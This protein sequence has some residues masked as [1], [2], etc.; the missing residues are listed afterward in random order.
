MALP[1]ILV[2]KEIRGGKTMFN[3]VLP[4][5]TDPGSEV[6]EALVA[7]AGKHSLVKEGGGCYQVAALTVDA[8]TVHFLGGLYVAPATLQ[9]VLAD[10]RTR[11]F[12]IESKA[13]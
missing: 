10:L 13:E 4:G 7:I 5:G 1:K 12:E 3:L 11:G 8:G 2:R 6:E 9:A